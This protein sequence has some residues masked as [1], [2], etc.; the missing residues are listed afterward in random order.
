ME[1][2]YAG[3][4]YVGQTD[5]TIQLETEK[6]LSGTTSAKVRYKGPGIQL[7][8]LTATVLN[9]SKGIIQH[10]VNTNVFNEAGIW[11]LWAVTTNAGGLV[12]IG[13]PVQMIVYA[14]GK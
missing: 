2:N 11:I 8:D 6:D 3:K 12:S 4:V 13:E 9:P 5:L 10:V 1:T 14:Q 7:G